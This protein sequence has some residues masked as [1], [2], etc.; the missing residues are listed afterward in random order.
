M[1]EVVRWSGDALESEGFVIF[2]GIL[3]S[4]LYIIVEKKNPISF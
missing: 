1:V 2:G 3:K 4:G